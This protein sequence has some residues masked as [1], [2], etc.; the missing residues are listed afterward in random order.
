MIVDLGVGRRTRTVL[1]EKWIGA[2]P[3]RDPA[4]SCGFGVFVAPM[5]V[6][7]KSIPPC[8][9]CSS[10]STNAHPRPGPVWKVFSLGATLWGGDRC[11]SNSNALRA[12][13]L[14]VFSDRRD[15]PASSLARCRWTIQLSARNYV[16]AHIHYV[17]VTGGRS[18]ASSPR[19]NYW[20]RDERPMMSD[21][22]GH[23]IQFLIFF[24][25]FNPR[26][27]IRMHPARPFERHARSTLSLRPIAGVGTPDIHPP[28]PPPSSRRIAR[29]PQSPCPSRSS[30]STSS[31]ASC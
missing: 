7:G 20:I 27:S 5:F 12:R 16:V 22:P 8:R 6:A 4:S 21:K 30:S 28:P 25:G 13:F 3:T 17:L 24:L 31:A 26:P 29:L 1:P 14:A 9:S 18:S 10:A 19:R 2:L 23:E 15:P 11:A